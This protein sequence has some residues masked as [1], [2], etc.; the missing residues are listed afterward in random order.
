MSQFKQEANLQ[1]VFK[2]VAAAAMAGAATAPARSDEL[3]W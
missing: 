1:G 3:E 2:L